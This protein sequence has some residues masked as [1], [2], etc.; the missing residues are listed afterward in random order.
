AGFDCRYAKSHVEKLICADTE[1]SRL[2]SKLKD[3]FVKV[4]NETS[5]HDGETGALIDPIGDEQRQWRETVRDR[6]P[7]VSCLRKAY[8]A[9]IRQVQEKWSEVLR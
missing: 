3:L 8:D 4:Q 5:G 9:R 2:D 7:D 6:C 1:L